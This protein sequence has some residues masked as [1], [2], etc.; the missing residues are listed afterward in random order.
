MKLVIAE[1]PS[2]GRSVAK[3]IGVIKEHKEE[4]YIECKDGFFITWVFGHIIEMMKPEAYNPDFKYFRMNN[5]SIIPE[6][7]LYQAKPSAVKQY[8]NIKKLTEKAT[9]IINCGDPDRE[10]Q[11]LIDELLIHFGNTKPVKRLLILD[12][13]PA[14]IR[15]SIESME[16]NSKYHSWYQ[17]GL[18]R[19]QAD[20]LIG[21]NFTPAFT[22]IG[23]KQLGIDGVISIGRVQTP[24]LKLIYDRD[25]AIKKYKPLSFYNLTATF[26]TSTNQKFNAKL[27][28]TGLNLPLDKDGRLLDQSQL[29]SVT[30]VIKNQQGNISKFEVKD[31]ETSQPLPFKLSDLQ[32]KANAKLG[33]SADD[34][35][36]VAQTL[37]EK[38]LTTYPRTACAYLPES[39]HEDAKS[40][41]NSLASI[42]PSEIQK[43]DST[44]KSRAFNDKQLGGESHFAII[45]TGEIVAISAL[46]SKE[47]EVYKI[48]AMQYIAQFYPTIKYQETTGVVT[49]TKYNFNFTG[50]V[51]K[52]IGWKQLFMAN[53]DIDDDESATEEDIQTLPPLALNQSVTHC[54][55]EIKKSTTTKPKPYTE[56][57]LIKTMANIHNELDNIVKTYYQDETE[58]KPIIDRYKKVL[59][60]TAGLGTEATRASTIDKLKEREYVTLVKKNLTITEKGISVMELLTSG[61]NLSDYSVLTSPLTTAIYEQQLDDVLTHKLPAETFIQD[62]HK[63]INSKI[64]QLKELYATIPAK[65]LVTTGNKCPECNSDMVMKSGKF[66]DFEA[67]SNYPTCKYRPPKETKAVAQLTGEKCPECNSDIVER[68][69]KFGKFASCS[70]YP[71]CKWT[72]PKPEKAPA[73]KSGK[74][75]PKCKSDLLNKKSKDGTKTFLGCSAFP[76]CKHM[77]W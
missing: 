53:N 25:V 38:Q 72:P 69:G 63:M 31:C 23:K 32:A 47:L 19:S 77:E 71:T 27:D 73:E 4:G 42:Y 9:L 13:K 37:Y 52:N 45:P 8:N 57:T 75:C 29:E 14:G 15:K 3:E 20:W 51:I 60:D 62:I 40:I 16:D 30:S 76:K 65:N 61:T 1:K 33:L 48:I 36:K 28:F 41:L 44:I 21:Y 55:D 56:G 7:W 6:K 58:A 70:N 12:P 35:L 59:K 17:A 10:G 67:C 18:L 46:S 74:K 5:L 2:L 26:T 39:L 50:K 49:C 34:V 24:T 22:L 54:G 11:L 66:G 68:D 64:T 43:A